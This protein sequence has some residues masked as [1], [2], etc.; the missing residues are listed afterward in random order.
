MADNQIMYERYRYS[1]FMC[2]GENE[3]GTDC[4]NKA[5]IDWADASEFNDPDESKP[6]VYHTYRCDDHPV[7]DFDY[8]PREIYPKL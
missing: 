1:H 7:S 8:E 4:E 2:E 3:D 6:T 5:T